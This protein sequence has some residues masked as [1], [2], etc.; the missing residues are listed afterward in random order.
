MNDIDNFNEMFNLNN[1]HQTI[2][3]L[4]GME[5]VDENEL[6]VHMQNGSTSIILI[7]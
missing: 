6:T 3:H 2:P 7:K 5:K 4:N 1:D